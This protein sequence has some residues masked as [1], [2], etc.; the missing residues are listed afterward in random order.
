MSKPIK[1][2]VRLINQK[3]FPDVAFLF[4]EEEYFIKKTIDFTKEIAK[5]LNY[6]FNEYS[7]KDYTITEIFDLVNEF[8]LFGG[9]KII[10]ITEFGSLKQKEKFVKYLENPSPSASIILV[11]FDKVNLDQ[12]QTYKKFRDLGIAYES[13]KYYENEILEFIQDRF[14][15]KK[16]NTDLEI[17]ELLYESIGN[18]LAELEAEIDKVA[19][20]YDGKQISKEEVKKVI[21]VSRE[22]TIFDLFNV[23][24]DKRFD[25][26]LMIGY[27]LLDHSASMVYIITMLSKYF[28][29]LLTF[30][31][32]KKI[33]G[34][35]DIVIAKMIGTAPRFLQDYEMASKRYSTNELVQIFRILLD[36]DFQLKSTS[37][38]EKTQYAM[39]ISEISLL[40]KR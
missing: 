4:G 26:A 15:K 22:Y 7:F 33:A 27:N 3:K 37:I 13:K 12:N 16:I 17:A 19:L 38:D 36:K 40:S 32:I 8:S 28:F 34:N 10:V 30:N 9:K 5:S 25:K 23:L 35:K 29:S 21:G 6:T 2:F 39:L 14:K 11:E 1:D 20:A 24:K 31:E 18:N